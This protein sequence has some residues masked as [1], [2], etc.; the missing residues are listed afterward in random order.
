MKYL[1]R[2]IILL[3]LILFV[4]PLA[5]AEINIDLPEKDLYNL[6]EKVAPMVSIKEDRD[7]DGFFNL[8]IFCDNYDLQ[9]YAIPLNLEANF[10]TQLT[11]PELPLSKSM[12][13]KCRL[14][15][16]FEATDEERIDSAWSKYFFVTGDLNITVEG[17]LEAKPGEDVVILGQVKKYSNEFLSNGEAKIT[18]KD[19]E[20]KVDII[21]GKFEHTI[22]LEDD[23]EAGKIPILI[24]VTDKYGNYGD[25]ILKLN[26]LP[27][28]TRIENRFNDGVLMPLDIFEA[29]VILYDHNNRVINGSIIN[30]R[31]LDPDERL[32][33][34]GDIY[35]LDYF[36]FETEK[37]QAPGN[38]FL[39]STFENIKEQSSFSIEVVRR[40]IMKQE[41]NF[42]H[43]ENVGNVE[44]K[45]EVTIILE[46]DDKT[47]LINKKINLEVGEKITI[48]L[49]E[50]VPQGVYD[51]ILP[52]ETVEEPVA[53]DTNESESQEVI[54]L[55]NVIEDV[56]IDDNR[57]VVKKTADGMSSITGAV[58][59][60]AGYVASKPLLASV[61]LVL[62]IL[63][64]ITRYSWGFI[65]NRVRGKKEDS[66]EHIFED[67]KYEQNEDNKPG[68]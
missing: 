49:S 10:R 62:I 47:Y 21:A 16:N 39:L 7:Y 23:V 18:F 43:V 36:E 34:E 31:I 24:V 38:Y 32:V 56:P 15:A 53:E 45:D 41:D 51:I 48:D 46:S 64:T 40:I 50:E 67:F 35:S 14:K 8:H 57:N 58:V 19:K 20:E 22:H 60:A 2:Y 13:T 9:Y 55:K 52:E 11:V 29:R 37:T 44:Y 4:I 28:P 68:N 1:K 30:V 61:I 6:G 65:K 54:G 59:G 63:G 17:D 25:K 33:A 3:F 26:A 27:I 42:V 12:T 66:T 5:Y